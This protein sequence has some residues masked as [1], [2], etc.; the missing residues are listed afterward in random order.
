MLNNLSKKTESLPANRWYTKDWFIILVFLLF[1]PLGLYLMWKYSKWSNIWKIVH[2]IVFGIPLLLFFFWWVRILF[3]WT[4]QNPQ[5]RKSVAE[6]GQQLQNKVTTT[7][8]IQTNGTKE[9]VNDKYGFRLKYPDNWN[10]LHQDNYLDNDFTLL[11][12]FNGTMVEIFVIKNS[13]FYSEQKFQ[14]EPF[15]RKDALNSGYETSDYLSPSGLTGKKFEGS[16][17][18]TFLTNFNLKGEFK[19]KII[20]VRGENFTYVTSSTYFMGDGTENFLTDLSKVLDSFQV[21]Q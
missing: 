16:A 13:D 6:V 15:S 10:L 14:V 9:L 20:Q 2:S 4:I 11:P 19:V 7:G 3:A 12:N 5:E 18:S 8:Y 21:V 17:S 1:T